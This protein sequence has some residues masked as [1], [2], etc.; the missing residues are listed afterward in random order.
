M[1]LPE[2]LFQEMTDFFDAEDIKYSIIDRADNFAAIRY[3]PSPWKKDGGIRT[4]VSIDFDENPKD[5]GSVTVH[6]ASLRVAACDEERAPEAF[7]RI[8]ELNRRYRWVKFWFRPE[9][10]T[11]N[12][13]ADAILFPGSVGKECKQY[14][15]RLS[16]ILEDALIEHDDLFPVS[17][18]MRGKPSDDGDDGGG[19]APSEAELRAMLAALM[20]MLGQ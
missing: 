12:A 19:D 15:L 11:L 16:D 7:V 17:P 8:N 5:D 3:A 9:D 6:F 4:R 14:A 18:E 10:N 2:D 20:E 1:G 13:D